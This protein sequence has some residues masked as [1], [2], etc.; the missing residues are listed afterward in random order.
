M[1]IPEATTLPAWLSPALSRPSD[2]VCIDSMSVN[3]TRRT[4]DRCQ[5]NLDTLQKTVLRCGV[6]CDWEPLVPT[7]LPAPGAHPLPCV[8]QDQGDR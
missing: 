8:P 3:L 2:N 6:M 5:G 7:M 4:L 1:A